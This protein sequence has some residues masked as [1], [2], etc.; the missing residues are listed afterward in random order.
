MNRLIVI[1]ILGMTLSAASAWIRNYDWF[2]STGFSVQET[3]D[4]GYIVTG[5]IPSVDTIPFDYDVLLMKTD[6]LGDT[7]WTRTYGGVGKDEGRCVRQSPDGG[8]IVVGSV[9]GYEYYPGN[10]WLLKTDEYGDTIWTKRYGSLWPDE[11]RWIEQTTDGGYIISGT[12]TP[13]GSDYECWLLKTDENGDT[14]WTKTYF[15]TSHGYCVQ[16]T[17]DGGYIIASP[18]GLIKT[19]SLGDTLWVNSVASGCVR[20]TTDGGYIQA[21]SHNQDVWI[22]KTDSVGDSVWTRTYGGEDNDASSSFQQTTDGGYI[23]FGSSV[24]F[25]GG[26]ILKTDSDGDTIWTRIYK[27][28]NFSFGQQTTDGCYIMTGLVFPYG[29]Q[30]LETIFLIKTDSLGYAGIIEEPTADLDPGLKIIPPIGQTVTLHYTNYPNGFYALVFDAAGRRVD[31]IQTRSS[32][33]EI[34]WGSGF[35]PS[36]YFIREVSTGSTVRVVIAR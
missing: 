9:D 33:G 24:S 3:S 5:R 15:F 19:D 2:G 11:G 16:Q 7:I 8:Y 20:Q 27:D 28:Y 31:E 34:T 25:G 26:W 22:I 6:S 4:S 29:P 21:T 30:T 14:L 10:L 18:I 36:V 35:S 1:V 12:W 32:T 13:E 23:I 17:T